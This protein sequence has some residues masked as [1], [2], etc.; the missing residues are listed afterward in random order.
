[1][2]R[3]QKEMDTGERAE[4]QILQFIHSIFPF[5]DDIFCVDRYLSYIEIPNI[6]QQ[7]KAM[8]IRVLSSMGVV[9][10]S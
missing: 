4:F 6:H 1:M 10:L 9:L 3:T 5:L 8:I 2:T 7:I